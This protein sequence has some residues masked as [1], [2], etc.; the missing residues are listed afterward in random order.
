MSKIEPL[1]EAIT[2]EI[3]GFLMMDSG[4]ELDE[5]MNLLYSSELFD[6]LHDIETGLY[7]EGSAYVYELL[8]DELAD[9]KGQNV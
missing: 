8:K 5:A 6:K 4:L 9:R 7:L 1:A 2:Q 3:V